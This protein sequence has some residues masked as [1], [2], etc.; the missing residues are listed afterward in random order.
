MG[1]MQ[2]LSQQ[3][4]Q[5]Q[6]LGARQ[7]SMGT[8]HPGG[9][10]GSLPQMRQYSAPSLGGMGG[11][12]SA[13]G[14]SAGPA[15]GQRLGGAG[16]QLAGGAGQPPG[17]PGLLG[18]PGGG[19]AQGDLLAMAMRK[20]Q[21]GQQQQQVHPGLAPGLGGM[22]KGIA[23]GMS[24]GP[25]VLQQLGPGGGQGAP[26]MLGGD[27][28][29]PGQPG[30]PDMGGP[31]F[32]MASDFP[33]LGGP[34]P[35]QGPGGAPGQGMPGV[36]HLGG[37]GGPM[38]MG[39][40]GGP[41][42]MPPSKPQSEF[43]IQSEDF[44][45]LPGAPKAPGQGGSDDEQH[46]HM[47]QGGIMAQ[48]PHAVRPGHFAGDG[49]AAVAGFPGG[50]RGLPQQQQ[51]GHFPL[52]QG[53]FGNPSQQPAGAPAG[54]APQAA[55]GGA[56]RYGLLGLLSV[57]RMQ[58]P[59]LTTLALGTDLTMLGLNLNST[60]SLW[61]TFA[62]PW[63]DAPAAGEPELSLPECFLT[64]QPPRLQPQLLN[65]FQLE[66]LFYAFYSM[67][68]DEGQLYAAEELYNRGWLYHKEH[69]L[70]LA[71]VDGSPPVEKTTAFERGSF[72]VFDSST[73]QR[74][75]KDN[76]VLS[77]DAVEVRPS[78][79]AQAAAAQA[80][81]ASQGPPVQPTHPGHPAAVQ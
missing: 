6:A 70:W 32:D 75:R 63:A 39:G 7:Q 8:V 2:G 9:V 12:L 44:P 21:Q 41:M 60:D 24:A 72:W 45:E 74:A 81:A 77:Y 34:R 62:S 26:G 56:A 30:A 79:A 35:G 69:K 14:V 16:M 61:K 18:S 10:N 55:G 68:G 47:Q 53:A 66:T 19:Y 4:Q 43:S 17:M 29:M 51:A 38:G 22:M 27:G 15:G 67:P 31:A 42:G 78:A 73:W 76:F 11:G 65:R 5:Q 3:Q 52:Q 36:P 48:Q 20:Q 49:R 37:P 1:G 58:D 13:G 80:Q 28:M 50:P 57:I 54:D 23:P 33:S 46:R 64:Q 40:P 25:G 59:D 71:R